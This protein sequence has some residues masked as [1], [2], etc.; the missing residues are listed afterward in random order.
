MS[1]SREVPLGHVRL[2]TVPQQKTEPV[3]PYA[4]QRLIHHG[5]I[6]CVQDGVKCVGAGKVCFRGDHRESVVLCGRRGSGDPVPVTVP[7][8]LACALYLAPKKK[9]T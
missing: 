2:R 7:E 6:A 4:V 8:S 9:K 3:V 1:M 5:F